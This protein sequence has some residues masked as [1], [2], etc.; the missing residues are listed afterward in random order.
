MATATTSGVVTYG[1]LT[2]EQRVF[3]ELNLLKRAIPNFLH[4]WFGLEGSVWPVSTLPLNSGHQI[5]WNKLAGFTAVTTPLTE[6]ITP[7]PQDITVTTVT[8][9]VREYGRAT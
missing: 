5:Q 4:I 3:Y 1:A 6:G 9:T 2:T 7:E 8:G